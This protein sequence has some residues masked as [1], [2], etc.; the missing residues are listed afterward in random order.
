MLASFCRWVVKSTVLP[1]KDNVPVRVTE[2]TQVETESS[3]QNLQFVV[4]FDDQEANGKRYENTLIFPVELVDNSLFAE[5]DLNTINAEI[6]KLLT[7]PVANLLLEGD[8][9]F[10]VPYGLAEEEKKRTLGSFIIPF[11]DL[12]RTNGLQMMNVKIRTVATAL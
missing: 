7:D 5:S 11:N 6:K 4:R 10:F 1:E 9:L 2:S 3:E 12:L 8:T